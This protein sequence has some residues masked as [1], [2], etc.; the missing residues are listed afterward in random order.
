MTALSEA[1]TRK[2]KIDVMLEKSGWIVKDRTKVIEEADTNQSD[3]VISLSL[4]FAC[5]FEHNPFSCLI[6]GLDN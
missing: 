5:L 3:F 4:G 2:Q 1:T 6:A